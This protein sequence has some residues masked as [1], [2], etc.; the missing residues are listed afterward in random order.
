[1]KRRLLSPAL[2]GLLF[3][4]L[5]STQVAF[6]SATMHS[7]Q[8][9]AEAPRATLTLTEAGA[10]GD[11]TTLNTASIQAAI[12]RLGAQ[13]G[14]TLVVPRGVFR[15]GALFL[16]PGVQLRLEEGAVLKGSTD[17]TDYPRRLTRI[18]GQLTEW[19]PALVN[20]EACDHLRING[21][22]TLDGSGQ[23][24]YTR[25][26]E[27]REHDPKT[28]NLAVERPRLLYLQDCRDVR[29]SGLTL[30][31]SGF[32]NL[33]LYRCSEVLVEGLRIEAP[34][35]RPPL[36]GPSTDGMDIDSCQ[37]VT[38]KGCFLSVNDDCICLKGTKGPFAMEDRDSPP[39]E[40]IRISDCTFVAGHGALTLGSEASIVRDVVME[41]CRVTGQMP[42]LRLKLRRDTPQVY[43][44]VHFRN[45]TLDCSTPC[46]KDQIVEVASWNQFFD[47]KGQ[48]S[49]HSTVRNISLSGLRGH[50]GAFG[51]IIGI[52]GQTE[53]RDIRLE[54][55][56]VTLEKP[57][58]RVE[59]AEGIV[60]KDVRVN[61]K[62]YQR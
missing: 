62:V 44:D 1:M 56:D 43:E 45:I 35:G 27:A 23:A 46:A 52:P 25:F 20:A 53:I 29:L 14:G 50:C 41:N 22:G 21:P 31:H 49:P 3:L 39:T 12:E 16:K 5:L 61:G 7:E 60:F 51:E 55:I 34:F 40:H 4:G 17:I 38:V 36:R 24:F 15:S 30:H 42:L 37:R 59:H 33:H 10:V 26:W 11:G 57:L 28:T 19:I 2:S 58:L 32:W 6:A 8:E 47:L 13:G 54:D 9:A 48:P 18:E